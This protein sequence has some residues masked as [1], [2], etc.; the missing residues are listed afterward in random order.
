MITTN[1][2]LHNYFIYFDQNIKRCFCFLFIFFYF[3]VNT[4][5][6]I[7]QTL[8]HSYEGRLLCQ[9]WVNWHSFLLEPHYRG[10]G[11]LYWHNANTRLRRKPASDIPCRKLYSIDGYY[12][13]Q[14]L[15][16]TLYVSRNVARLR[17]CLRFDISGNVWI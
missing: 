2:K 12:T 15:C 14:V 13:V 3:W 5:F 1:K 4:K 10:K 11:C 9:Y 16:G 7:V 8:L 6:V 17:C